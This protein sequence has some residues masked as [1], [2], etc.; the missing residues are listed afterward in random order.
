MGAR[1]IGGA[2]CVLVVLLGLVP[3]ALMG[4]AAAAAE[5]VVKVGTVNVRSVR[6]DL[7]PEPNEDPWRLRRTAV[8]RDILA[9]DLDVVGLQEASQNTRYAAL[10]EDGPTQYQDIV[11]GLN[12]SGARYAVTDADVRT[13]RDTRIV[14]NTDTLV[15][16]RTGAYQYRHQSGGR[17]DQRFLVWAVFRIRETGDAFFFATTHL[18][19][20]SESLQLGQWRELIAR[21]EQLHGDLPVVIGGDFQTSKKAGRPASTMM[22]EMRRAGWKDVL[23]QRPGTP[24]LKSARPDRRIRAW[25]NSMNGFDRSVARYSYEKHHGYAGNSIDWIFA[26]SDLPVTRYRVVA[27][28]KRLRLTGVIPSDHFLVT[29]R[30]VIS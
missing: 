28:F 1:R 18:V 9:E 8:V 29:A 4:P 22:T 21:V 19:N 20:G 5:A 17:N 14:F 25:V 30:I 7:D 26:S 15:V 24:V 6:H 27:R 23:N 13:S 12:E 16:L 11:A 3:G 10:M 2:W